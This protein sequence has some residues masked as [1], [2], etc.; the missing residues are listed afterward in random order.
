MAFKIKYFIIALFFVVFCIRSNFL[1]AT[2]IENE[3]GV[4]VASGVG[5]RQI[6]P[7]RLGIQQSFGRQLCP[8][9]TACWPV[10]GY[11]EG[12]FYRLQGGKRG[13]I[14][15]SHREMS[16]VALAG[17][18]RMGPKEPICDGLAAWDVSPYV[19]VGVGI[20]WVSRKEISG[21]ELGIPFQFEDRIGFGCRFGNKKQYDISYRAVHFSNAYL[22]KKNHGINLHLLVLGYWFN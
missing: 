14:L 12:S 5:V 18:F 8:R 9:N 7:V 19:D 4:S 10:S 16:I 13:P 22:G 2:I 15:P 1:Q 21:R 11:W 3:R 20:S 17:V 6:I